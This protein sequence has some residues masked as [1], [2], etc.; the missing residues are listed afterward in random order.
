MHMYAILM[1]S[2]RHTRRIHTV[3]FF[4]VGVTGRV[5]QKGGHAHYPDY[6]SSVS[7]SGK[8]TRLQ[9]YSVYGKPSPS[10]SCLQRFL[11]A[12]Q[13]GIKR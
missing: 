12:W 4:Y 2:A 3:T 11:I 5:C 10:Y 13:A 6:S 1:A 7:Y 8:V 9:K